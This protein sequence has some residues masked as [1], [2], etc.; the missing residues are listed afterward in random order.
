MLVGAKL[1]VTPVGNPLTVSATA[2]LN[3]LMT[4]VEIVILAGVPVTTLTLVRFDASVKLDANI[5]ILMGAV[6]VAPVPLPVTV[7]V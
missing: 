4:P 6:T 7:R 3:P 5:V 2:D 1:A